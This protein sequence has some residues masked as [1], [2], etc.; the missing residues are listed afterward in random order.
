[1]PF[2]IRTPF[3][4]QDNGRRSSDGL[5]LRRLATLVLLLIAFSGSFATEL[6]ADER[7]NFVIIFADDK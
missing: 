1:M 5:W 3:T 4:I 7:P 6:P 2:T